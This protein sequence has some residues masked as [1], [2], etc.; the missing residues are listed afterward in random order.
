MGSYVG[1]GKGRIGDEKVT[2]EPT[3]NS[4]MQSIA[5]L[6]MYLRDSLAQASLPLR[7]VLSSISG[8]FSVT[9]LGGG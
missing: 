3:K 2:S 9:F 5:P 1:T 8:P 7:W 6:S 4:A